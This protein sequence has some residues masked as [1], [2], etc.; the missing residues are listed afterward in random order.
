LHLEDDYVGRL[1]LEDE[2]VRN[3]IG[4]RMEKTFMRSIFRSRR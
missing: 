4:E 2:E 1:H 3:S